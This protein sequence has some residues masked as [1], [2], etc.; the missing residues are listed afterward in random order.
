MNK[1]PE[2][3]KRMERQLQDAANDP[4]KLQRLGQRLGMTPD[5]LGQLGDRMGVQGC[6]PNGCGPRDAAGPAGQNASACGPGGCGPKGAAAEGGQA[7]AGGAAEGA[8]GEGGGLD[9]QQIMDFITNLIQ[10]GGGA[11][12]AKAGGQDLMKQIEQAQSL[13]ELQQILAQAGDPSQLPPELQQ[14]VVQ[15]AQQLGAGAVA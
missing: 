6:G 14:A 9:L 12:D 2:M 1:R 5:Q 13:E 15:K 10:G 11:G 3:R 4:Q 7:P 8:G